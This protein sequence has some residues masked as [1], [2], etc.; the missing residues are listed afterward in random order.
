M[1]N[2]Y[3]GNKE[4]GRKLRRVIGMVGETKEERREG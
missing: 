2:R 1:S 4:G 3:K